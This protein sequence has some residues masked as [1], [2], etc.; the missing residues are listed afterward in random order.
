MVTVSADNKRGLW[1]SSL[2]QAGKAIRTG[3]Q[4]PTEASAH[5]LLLV[6]LTNPLRGI[7]RQQYENIV[8]Y[9]PEGVKKPRAKVVIAGNDSFA[10][11]FAGLLTRDA[12]APKLRA[13][14]NFLSIAAQQIARFTLDMETSADPRDLILINWAHKNLYPTKEF[15]T[16]P[17]SLVPSITGQVV[18][19]ATI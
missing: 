12:S 3:G 14:R 9:L 19:G 8:S 16:L 7:N 17:A 15:E 13:G 1:A 10:A 11:A 18:T 2:F 5:T 4:L 6:A